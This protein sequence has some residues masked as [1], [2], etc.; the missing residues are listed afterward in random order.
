MQATMRKYIPVIFVAMIFF[1]VST[2]AQKP[3]VTKGGELCENYLLK[4]IAN[5]KATGSRVVKL[6]SFD[7]SQET[8]SPEI[9]KWLQ[10]IHEDMLATFELQHQ[11]EKGLILRA[12]VAVATGIAANFTNWHTQFDNHSITFRSL[13]ENP[14]LIYLDK[15]GRLNYYSIDYGRTFLDKGRDWNNLTLDLMRYRIRSD[16]ESQ[17]V[18]K[19]LNVKCK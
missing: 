8:L 18:S 14:K 5:D 11:K 16:G 12:N 13:S 7:T 15:R 9:K 17:L 10:T 19:E 3:V 1:S 2:N 6:K 4:K